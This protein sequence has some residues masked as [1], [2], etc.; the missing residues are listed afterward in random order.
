MK[1]AI[2]PQHSVT[3]DTFAIER[4]YPVAPARV[5]AAWSDPVTKLRW[6]SCEESWVVSR[7]VMDFRAGGREELAVGP[8]GGSVHAFD[9][10]YHDIVPERRIVYAYDMRID[11]VLISVSLTPLEFEPRGRGTRMRFT[12]Q[13]AF[14]DGHQNPAERAEGTR[15]GLDNLRRYLESLGSA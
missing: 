9:G 5:F 1:T 14:L 13:G 3:H 2:Q 10:R 12:E 4:I 11:G 8:A 7:H 6:F 15:V